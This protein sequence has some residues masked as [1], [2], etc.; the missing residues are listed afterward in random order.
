MT[1]TNRRGQRPALPGH[2]LT[3]QSRLTSRD[4]TLLRLLGQHQVLTTDHITALLYP[5]R[6]VAQHRLVKLWRW[7]VLDR[8]RPTTANGAAIR[9][10]WRYTLG[11]AGAT[12]LAAHRGDALPRPSTVRARTLRVANHPQLNHLLGVNGFFA[13]LAAYTATHTDHHLDGWLDERAATKACGTLARPDGLATWRHHQRHVV[14]C[15]EHDT[16]TESLTR[17]AAKLDGYANL[18]DAFGPQL[19]VNGS[20]PRHAGPFW[21]L[22]HLHSDQ[23]EAALRRALRDNPYAPRPGDDWGVATTTHQHHTNDPG[24]DNWL[25]LHNDHRHALAD[26][27]HAGTPR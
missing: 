10:S 13:A 15:V 16:G 4:H 14:I 1:T 2:P 3:L 27:D 12:L 17:V 22:L 24:G 9:S 5:D 23:R 7:H 21:V 6:T 18:A 11:P 20:E 26:L 19:A 25:A 8:F